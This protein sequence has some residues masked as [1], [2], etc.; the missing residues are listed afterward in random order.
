MDAQAAIARQSRS[1]LESAATL[2]AV[3]S[4]DQ[5]ARI[6]LEVRR[7]LG[8]ARP[9]VAPVA[10]IEEICRA[11]GLKLRLRRLRGRHDGLQAVLSPCERGFEV[12][13]DTEPRDGWDTVPEAVRT[14]LHRHRLRF[15]V[16]HEL[17]HTLFYDR[18]AACPHRLV[19]DSD[20]QEA[21]C[22]SFARAFLV[23]PATISPQIA[24]PAAV[25]R[26]A[27]RYDVSLEVAVRAVAASRP[28]DWF[29]LYVRRPDGFI[30]Q[31]LSSAIVGPP[32]MQ[33]WTRQLEATASGVAARHNESGWRG[34]AL[35]LP[36]RRQVLV[37]AKSHERPAR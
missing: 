21:F 30:T 33:S 9:N 35:E 26:L 13:V 10:V 23:P 6:A 16:A 11:A 2:L 29:G 14:S 22:D 31:W 4:L 8:I 1:G 7:R 3:P 28:E 19:P 25:V 37:V 15:R 24:E 27:R 34:T 36:V 20:E 12:T 5:A 18:T 17:A 32:W